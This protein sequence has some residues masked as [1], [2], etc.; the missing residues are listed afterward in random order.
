MLLK[1]LVFFGGKGGVGKSTLACAL[2]L[3]LSEFGKTLLLSIDPAHSLSHIMQTELNVSPKEVKE[4]LYAAELDGERLVIDYAERVLRS[5]KELVPSLGSGLREYARY[6]AS[7][8]TALDTAMLDRVVDFLY[9]GYDYVVL[10]SAPTGQMVR[11]FQTMHMVSAWFDLLQK[12][13][14]SRAKVEAFMGREDN[15]TRLIASRKERIELLIKTIRERGLLLIV[16]NEEPLSLQEAKELQEKLE[17]TVKVIRVMNRSMS[18]GALTVEYV[19]SPYG[20][21]GLKRLKLER[22]IQEVLT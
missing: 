4:N 8:P 9:E 11:L 19:E 3:A 18:K 2:S 17:G 5:L 20:L 1:R 22:L 13:A 12:V 15:L 21:E 10:D 16:A 14:K 6:M 7:S